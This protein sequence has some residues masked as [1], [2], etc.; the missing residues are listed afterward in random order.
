MQAETWTRTSSTHKHA[1]EHTHEHTYEPTMSTRMSTSM[2]THVR[3]CDR[4]P[5]SNLP[6]VSLPSVTT[7]ALQPHDTSV[8]TCSIRVRWRRGPRCVWES[9]TAIEQHHDISHTTR[10][11]PPQHD[12]TRHRY[13][14]TIDTTRLM[15]SS[16]LTL[17]SVFAAR[18]NCLR[19]TLRGA[20]CTNVCVLSSCRSQSTSAAPSCQEA[21]RME[22]RSGTRWKSPKPRSLDVTYACGRCVTSLYVITCR[23]IGVCSA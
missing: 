8:R 14:I 16:P 9:E 11:P 6:L 19:S 22:E 12:G 18:S 13:I 3:T 15:R 7:R 23:P 4:S 17:N 20:T 1:H 21:R 5:H 10:H 2:S